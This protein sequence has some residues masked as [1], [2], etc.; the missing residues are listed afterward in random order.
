MHFLFIWNWPA[1]FWCSCVLLSRSVNLV[2]PGFLFSL[3]KKHA[4]CSMLYPISINKSWSWRK[5]GKNIQITYR[6]GICERISMLQVYRC[7]STWHSIANYEKVFKKWFSFILL[8]ANSG[9]MPYILVSLEAVVHRCSVK[10][11][12]L[13]ISQKSQEN[14]Y[15]RAS[16]L[17]KLQAT[18]LKKRLWH[19]CLPVNFV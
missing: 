3:I 11:V 5:I 4:I 6:Q 8:S 10:N 18:L 14:N 16:F 9:N 15:A 2:M 7:Q 1:K 12:F 17:I 13:E 19:R